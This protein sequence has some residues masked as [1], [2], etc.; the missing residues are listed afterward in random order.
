MKPTTVFGLFIADL[1]SA[2]DMSPYKAGAG[3]EDGFATFVEEYYRI[4]EDKTA[5][6]TFTDFWTT[7]GELIIAG[8]VYQGY[9]AMLAVKQALLPVDGNKS[10][11]HLIRGSE[12]V[13]EAADSKTYVAD[14][15]IQTT[16]T[17]GNCSQA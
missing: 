6:T 13:G 7:D 9:D 12:L 1:V 8:N 17:P 11:W 14:I 15:V 10:W 3:V 2:V 16:Y 4:S 5:T